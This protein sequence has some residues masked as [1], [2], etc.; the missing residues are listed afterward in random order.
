MVETCL[1]DELIE[2]HNL[3]AK[4]PRV[5]CNPIYVVLHSATIENSD[6]I[7]VQF[8]SETDREDS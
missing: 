2:K 8:M 5:A 6:E 1:V 3:A 7:I 4:G